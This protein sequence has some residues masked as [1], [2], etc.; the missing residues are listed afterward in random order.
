M[1]VIQKRG[2]PGGFKQL[3][4]AVFVIYMPKKRGV[5]TLLPK[6]ALS[7]RGQGTLVHCLTLSLRSMGCTSENLVFINKTRSGTM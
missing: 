2:V 5:A 1:W 4:R 6:E 7:T 3:H